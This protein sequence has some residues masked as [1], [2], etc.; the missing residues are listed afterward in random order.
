MFVFVEVARKKRNPEKN[1]QSK[2]ED[3][4]QTQPTCER[5]HHRDIPA[6]IISDDLDQ[7]N[8]DL[9]WQKFWNLKKYKIGSKVGGMFTRAV[10]C[11]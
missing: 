10:W 4:Q 6:P 5:S 9:N 7:H 8:K 11:R 3:Q 1:P 2:D